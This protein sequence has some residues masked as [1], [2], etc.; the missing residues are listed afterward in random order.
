MKHAMLDAACRAARKRQDE[1]D[2]VC[3]GCMGRPGH[4]PLKD[5]P[6]CYVRT[7]YDE[8][9]RTIAD[10]ERERRRAYDKE[11]SKAP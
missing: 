3:E 1:L 6:D 5:C 2:R 11:R 7:E 8:A 10:C 4:D 9:E